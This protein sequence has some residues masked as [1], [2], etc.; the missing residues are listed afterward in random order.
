ML[1]AATKV[2]GSVSGVANRLQ[3]RL[4]AAKLNRKLAQERGDGID[5]QE[6][7]QEY[8]KNSRILVSRVESIC[9]KIVEQTEPTTEKTGEHRA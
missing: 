9:Q 7:T 6:T 1:N 4:L 8:Q 2:D 3:G 5:D